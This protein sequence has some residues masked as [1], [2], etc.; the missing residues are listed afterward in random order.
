V[1]Y[2]LWW[3]LEAYL[4]VNERLGPMRQLQA[5]YDRP[6]Y[7]HH[8]LMNNTLDEDVYDRLQSKR[9]VQDSL[10]SAMKRRME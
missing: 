8:I 4:Q 5:G 6:V 7:V 10:M 1:H 9:S 2:S 3:N